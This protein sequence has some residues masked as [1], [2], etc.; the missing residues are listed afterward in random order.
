MSVALAHHMAAS[1]SP[2]CSTSDGACGLGKQWRL[3]QVLG[4][5]LHVGDPK[6]TLDSW[7][8]S[9]QQQAMQSFGE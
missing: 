9:A 4:P 1:L 8:S 7:F 3:V 6:E 2:G 5:L